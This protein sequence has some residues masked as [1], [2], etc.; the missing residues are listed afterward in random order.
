M[1]TSSLAA[2][3]IVLAALGLSPASGETRPTAFLHA[4]V[5]P[6]DKEGVMRDQTV[7]VA[8]GR[9]TK[10]G[11]AAATTAPKGARLVDAT[12]LYLSPGLAD[13]H[14]HVYVPQELTLYVVNGVTTVFNLNGHPVHLGWRHR[15]AK[16]EILGP[17]STPR[18]RPSTARAARRK[19]SWRSTGRAPP[20]TTPSRSTTRSAK[21]SIRRSSPKPSARAWS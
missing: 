2:R 9:I 7:V 19:R 11:P 3:L 17:R 20:A 5:V 8:G 13:M 1:R 16:G 15:I 6:M 18:G 14:V 12:G 21:P 10:I 4:S